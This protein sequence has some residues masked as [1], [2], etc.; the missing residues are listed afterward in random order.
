MELKNITNRAD[1][2]ETDTIQEAIKKHNENLNKTFERA[3]KGEIINLT[4]LMIDKEQIDERINNI[5]IIK[6]II[7][8]L[9]KQEAERLKAQ[10]YTNECFFK[11]NGE[12]QEGYK[13]H[14]LEKKNYFYIDKGTSGF[15]MIDKKTFYVYTIKAYGQK[16]RVLGTIQDKERILN[17]AR[18]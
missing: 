6:N 13:Y 8:E 2:K 14:L 15:L 1:I 16:N 3:E 17:Y 9:N 11:P 7:K 4:D 10:G 18:W 5:E 12:L